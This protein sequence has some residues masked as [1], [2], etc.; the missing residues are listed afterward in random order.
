MKHYGSIAVFKITNDVDDE[1][2]YGY[3][4]TSLSSRFASLKQEATNP[5]YQSLLHKHIRK[6]GKDRFKISLVESLK[7]V[8]LDEVKSRINCFSGCLKNASNERAED[9]LQTDASAEASAD[10]KQLV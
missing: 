4:S 7:D 3:T 6:L 10:A 9:E 1:T 8:T 2:F 5:R